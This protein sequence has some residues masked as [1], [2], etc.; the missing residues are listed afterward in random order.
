[1]K[2]LL[3]SCR[4]RNSKAHNTTTRKKPTNLKRGYRVYQNLCTPTEF[5]RIMNK[6]RCVQSNPVSLKF[7]S[8]RDKKKQNWSL[9]WNSPYSLKYTRLNKLFIIQKVQCLHDFNISPTELFKVFIISH[10][11]AALINTCSKTITPSSTGPIPNLYAH[12][13]WLS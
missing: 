11:K 2:N 10:N 8:A 1:M 13:N 3:L 4:K 12:V 7:V 5:Q 9:I 6:Q